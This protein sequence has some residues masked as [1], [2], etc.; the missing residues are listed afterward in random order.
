MRI[1]VCVKEV[2]EASAARRIDPDTK[3][4]VRAGTQALNEFD[5]HALEEA[6]RAKDADP[7]TDVVAVAMGPERAMETLRK[8]L[9][10]GADRALLV[11]DEALAGADLV[12]TARVLGAAL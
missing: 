5:T 9:A 10:M 3:R 8:A 1:A 4:L 11:T 7:S 6:L 2:P 12:V